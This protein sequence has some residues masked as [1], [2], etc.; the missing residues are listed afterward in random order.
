VW[1]RSSLTPRVYKVYTTGDVE[2]AAACIFLGGSSGVG[3]V[4]LRVDITGWGGCAVTRTRQ[5]GS[6]HAG[7]SLAAERVGR[8]ARLLGTVETV[9]PAP[10]RVPARVEL[11]SRGR[12]ALTEAQF[13]SL[14]GKVPGIDIQEMESQFVAW[15]TDNGS[16]PENYVAALFGIIKQKVKREG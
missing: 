14:R 4:P 11:P 13:N 15:N 3:T 12:S 6:T 7:P 10:T 9:A 2:Q 8:R 5:T 16:E 1:V